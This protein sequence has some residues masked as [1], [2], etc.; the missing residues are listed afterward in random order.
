M[1]KQQSVR[2]CLTEF[3]ANNPSFGNEGGI[4]ERWVWLR[5]GWI[6]VPF[7]NFKA[8][9]EIIYLHDVNHII[10]DYNTGWQGEVSVAAW[11]VSTGMGKFLVG[12]LFASFAM[13]FGVFFYPRV[14]FHAFMRGRFTKSIFRM[15]LP[16][17]DILNMKLEALQR[18]TGHQVLKSCSSTNLRDKLLF[19]ISGVI[20][21]LFFVSPFVVFFIL[22]CKWVFKV[23]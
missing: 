4:Y 21:A 18:L 1:R 8:R 22:L 16:K 5:F 20:C 23:P 6:K 2:E 9:S 14:V 13:G 10:N 12:W 11:E 7:P 15:N 3:Y 17:E 19:C